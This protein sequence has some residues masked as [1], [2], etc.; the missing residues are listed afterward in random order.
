M[1]GRCTSFALLLFVPALALLA[2]PASAEDEDPAKADSLMAK[3]EQTLSHAT[4]VGHFTV[5]G[6]EG[7][8]LTDERY[9]LG[10]VKQLG[11]DQWLIQARIRYGE[12]DVTLP[13]TLP[14]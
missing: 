13:L 7:Q 12:H 8:R 11:G 14:I 1:F 10:E 9:E 6:K 3:L 5:T 2:F 4:L